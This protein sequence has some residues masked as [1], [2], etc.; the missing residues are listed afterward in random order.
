MPNY[1]TNSNYHRSNN[2]SAPLDISYD[3]LDSQYNH[4]TGKQD[5]LA[6]LP[7]AMAYV[8]WQLWGKTFDLDKALNYGTLFPELYKPFLGAGGYR[9]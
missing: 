9:S 5:D 7:L 4:T 6:K 8:P 2:Y 3:A 1:R